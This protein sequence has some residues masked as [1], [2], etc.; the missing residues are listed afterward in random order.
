MTAYNHCTDAN[1][2]PAAHQR[3]IRFSRAGLRSDTVSCPARRTTAYTSN[4]VG[5]RKSLKTKPS[6]CSTVTA[7][8]SEA[9]CTVFCETIL[10]CL[11]YS[12]NELQTTTGR[13][14]GSG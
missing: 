5:V 14:V 11:L 8:L 13:I 6:A 10:T 2:L 7:R 12:R 9:V 4:T 1:V 3:A